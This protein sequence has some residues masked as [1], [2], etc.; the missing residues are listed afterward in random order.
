MVVVVHALVARVDLAHDVEVGVSDVLLRQPD[1]GEEY[2][3]VGLHSGGGYLRAVGLDYLKLEVVVVN[4]AALQG[5]PRLE[6]KLSLSVVLVCEGRRRARALR[7][8]VGLGLLHSTVA[9]VGQRYGIGVLAFVE[10]C[11]AV[12]VLLRHVLFNYIGIGL[13]VVRF[14]EVQAREGH[15]S[16]RDMRRGV[17]RRRGGVSRADNSAGL[18]VDKREAEL[19]MPYR[20]AL[21]HLGQIYIRVRP[22]AVVVYKPRVLRLAG[23]YRSLGARAALYRITVS[24]GLDHLVIDLGHYA[25]DLKSLSVGQCKLGAVSDVSGLEGLILALVIL[26]VRV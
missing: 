10:Y 9:V 21:E 24:R 16:R 7:A 13:S 25:R 8:S 14:G 15:G 23:S 12:R 17:V 6:L 19:V 22:G 18:S 2:R 11:I 3:S 1:A 26:C 5:L 4:L 20:M